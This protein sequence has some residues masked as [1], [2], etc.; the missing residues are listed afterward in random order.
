MLHLPIQFQDQK[1]H[2]FVLR[3]HLKNVKNLGK[4]LGTLEERKKEGK[5]DP[6]QEKK[7][8]DAGAIVKGKNGDVLCD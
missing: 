5:L 7:L 3:C 8:L 6:T 4:W 2:C 1:G